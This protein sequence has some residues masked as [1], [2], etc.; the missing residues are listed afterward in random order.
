MRGGTYM[1]GAP[2]Q[3]S[4]GEQRYHRLHTLVLVVGVLALGTAMGASFLAFQRDILLGIAITLAG[5]LVLGMLFVLYEAVRIVAAIE[6]NTRRANSLTP[7]TMQMTHGMNSIKNELEEMSRNLQIVS[8]NT[9]A[10]T[11]KMHSVSNDVQAATEKL[12]D[13]AMYSRTTAMLLHF[14]GKQSPQPTPAQNGDFAYDQAAA[15]AAQ[16][17]EPITDDEVICDEP[18]Y[19]Q[20]GNGEHAPESLPDDKLSYR[21]LS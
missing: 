1:A 12:Q 5:L 21:E 16:A 13:I 9:Q 20:S 4:S 6:E 15:Q 17:A 3:E 7:Y 19:Q 10:L 14:Q 11:E 2:L 18:T 8:Y